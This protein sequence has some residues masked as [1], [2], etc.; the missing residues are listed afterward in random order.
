MNTNSVGVA[1]NSPFAVV[2]NDLP[3]GQYTV[4][5]L[6][7]DTL[8]VNNTAKAVTV[9]VDQPPVVDITRPTNGTIYYAPASFTVEA[10]A[11]DSGGQVALV[12][13][14]A[15]PLYLGAATRSPFTAVARNLKSGKYVLTARA[16]D[17]LGGMA[18][19]A[20]VTVIVDQPPE[21][22]I[23]SPL[24]G[25][26]FSLATSVTMEAMASDADGQVAKVDFYTGTT[27]LGTATNSPY[28]LVVSNLVA[29]RYSLTV[30]ATDELGVWTASSA[31]QF[32]IS[33]PS[34]VSLGTAQRFGGR[35]VSA[36][37]DR[38]DALD[39]VYCRGH[40]ELPGLVS[41]HHQ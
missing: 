9:T 13:F 28:R 41:P 33:A 10:Q 19:S 11:S 20:P 22:Q 37:L 7:T 4:S 25:S 38:R 14:L 32:T 2:V 15:E 27:L 6:A 31:V 18:T 3:R 29:G 8:G 1:T 34:G 40:D 21:V 24:S 12:E 17:N 39:T 26:T 35:P 16:T 5:A 36:H 23:T 30:R